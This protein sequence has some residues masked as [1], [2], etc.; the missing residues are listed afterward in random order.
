MFVI[1]YINSC[2]LAY[3]TFKNMLGRLMRFILDNLSA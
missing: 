2:P 3:K 1:C